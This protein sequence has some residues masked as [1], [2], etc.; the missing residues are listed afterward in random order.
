MSD[1]KVTICPPGEALGAG[2][3]QRWSRNRALGRSGV[4]DTK[5]ERKILKRWGKPKKDVADRWLERNAL[6]RK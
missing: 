4:S 2:D 6:K 3:L 1:V 5:R